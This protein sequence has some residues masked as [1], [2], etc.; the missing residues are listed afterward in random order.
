[1]LSGAAGYTYGCHDIWQMYTIGVEPVSQARTGWKEALNLPGSRQMLY[2]K[3]LLTSFPWQKM[4]NNQDLILSDN[5]EDEGYIVSSIGMDKDFII[6]YTPRGRPIQPDLSK[7]GSDRVKAYWF[8]PRS[9]ECL[10]LDSY[11]NSERPTFKPWATGRG[12][13]FLLI[14]LSENSDIK[15]P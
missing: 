13:D 14:I 12:S 10:Y 1:M 9:G 6:A 8:N 7:I 2:M 5:P 3:N 15:L 11:S 4:V